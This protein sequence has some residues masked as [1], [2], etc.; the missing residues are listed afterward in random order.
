MPSV[1]GE[2]G[3]LEDCVIMASAF[4]LVQHGRASPVG[5]DRRIGV[6]LRGPSIRVK[7]VARRLGTSVAALYHHLPA[8]RGAVP[9]NPADKA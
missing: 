7:K 8:R 9:E 6:L 4:R 5:K 2:L 1:E 3:D